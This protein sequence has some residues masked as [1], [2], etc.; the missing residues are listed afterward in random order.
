MTLSIIVPAIGPQ[1]DLDNTLVSVLENRPGDAEVL[2][3]H[4]QD[5][6]DPYQLADEVRFVSADSDQ[7]LALL[8]AAV[9]ESRGE[10]VHVLTGGV[11]VTAGWT[12]PVLERFVQDPQTAAVA[13]TLQSSR[14]DRLCGVRY[15]SGGTAKAVRMSRR[16]SAVVDGPCLEAGFFH[17]STLATIGEF[18]EFLSIA[19]A[20]A[21][22]AAKLKASGLACDHEPDCV[23]LGKMQPRPRGYHSSRQ[24]ERVYRRHR[25]GVGAAIMHWAATAGNVTRHGPSLGLLSSALGHCVGSL[26][27][28]WN[29]ETVW[30]ADGCDEPSTI[31]FP[32]KNATDDHR[33]VEYRRSA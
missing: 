10:F 14:H 3:P 20:N 29:P 9:T 1:S 6:E 28:R 30:Q 4:T 23:V 12:E 7:P 31:R 16:R 11:E 17:R 19:H 22:V 21:D 5:Y 8:N 2:V 18:D 32:N 15:R 33:G 13:A 24:L 26:Q 25:D 27:A